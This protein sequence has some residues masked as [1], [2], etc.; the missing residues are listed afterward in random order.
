MRLYLMPSLGLEFESRDHRPGI[1]LRHLP[2]D[3]KFGIFLGE[4]LGQQLQFV[5]INRLLLVGT[6]QQAA[7]RQFEAAGRDARQRRLW[8]YSGV[9]ALR[10]FDIRNNGFG[11]IVLWTAL[12]SLSSPRLATVMRSMPVARTGS[13]VR[14]ELRSRNAPESVEP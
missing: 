5:G 9:G 11:N 4:H 7:G 13:V 14:P 8:L 3:I 10:D 6:M 12:R 1:D 2:V